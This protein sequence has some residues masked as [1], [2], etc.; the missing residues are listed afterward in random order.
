[1]MGSAANIALSPREPEIGVKSWLYTSRRA[2]LPSA[3][4]IAVRQGRR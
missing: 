1:M 2:T 4:A 3:S